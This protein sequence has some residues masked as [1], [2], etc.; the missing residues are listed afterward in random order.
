A[1]PSGD[2]LEDR[3]GDGDRVVDHRIMP[4]ALEHAH[5]RLWD[6]A[7]ETVGL[8]RWRD[9]ISRAPGDRDGATDLLEPFSAVRQRP[10][11]RLAEPGSQPELLK[12]TDHL[13]G[14]V[15]PWPRQLHPGTG[16]KCWP[17]DGSRQ[18]AHKRPC[19]R[20]RHMHQPQ[21]TPRSA[22]LATRYDAH[23]NRRPYG[24]TQ[25]APSHLDAHPA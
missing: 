16:Q 23:R 2:R 5:L 18:R 12:R 13:G 10:V 21:P 8:P 19:R 25:A 4:E 17:A 24:P 11:D 22:V 20:E 6:A 9:Q 15:A 7:G 1:G 3:A 14:L